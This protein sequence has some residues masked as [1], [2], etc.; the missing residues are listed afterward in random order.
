MK[1]LIYFY[2][3]PATGKTSIA[4]SCA[5]YF[6]GVPLISTDIFKSYFLLQNPQEEILSYTSD[7]A[8]KIYG[9]L[10]ED[11]LLKGYE[12]LSEKVLIPLIPLIKELFKTYTTVFIEGAHINNS[13]LKYLKEENIYLL[14]VFLPLQKN[15]FTDSTTKKLK[16]RHK[17]HN[18]WLENLSGIESLNKILYSF[19]NSFDK[20][21]D[22]RSI[23]PSDLEI[24]E[25]S[26]ILSHHLSIYVESPKFRN[27]SRN[28]N[29]IE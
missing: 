20:S 11:T 27:A 26:Y 13:F 14:G 16:I 25:F 10:T 28:R 6:N 22:I 9:N 24:N 17:T 18:R 5:A 3:V 4:S 12:N 7:T 23:F 8:W 1:N 21:L 29:S 15:R 19:Q 2:G